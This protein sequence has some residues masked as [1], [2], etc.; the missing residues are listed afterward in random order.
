MPLY[1]LLNEAGAVIERRR[2]ATPVRV[3][4][5][6]EGEYANMRLA[7]VQPDDTPPPPEATPLTPEDVERLLLQV[8]GITRARIDQAKKDRGK[9]LP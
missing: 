6:A 2:T 1:E 7:A 9:P 4:P 8:P 5:G 3:G